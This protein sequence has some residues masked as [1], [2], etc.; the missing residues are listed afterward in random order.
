MESLAITENICASQGIFMLTRPPASCLES[1]IYLD[2]H[3]F[4]AFKTRRPTCKGVFRPGAS[5]EPFALPP[6]NSTRHLAK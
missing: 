3:I 6:S 1:K 2:T 4:V 5:S